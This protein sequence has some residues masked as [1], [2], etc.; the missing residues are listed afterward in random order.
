MLSNTCSKIQAKYTVQNWARLAGNAMAFNEVL[1]VAS[2]CNWTEPDQML[3]MAC[4][5]C[6]L[7]DCPTARL[8]DCP[9][10]WGNRLGQARCHIYAKVALIVT[11]SRVSLGSLST[12]PGKSLRFLGRLINAINT[13]MRIWLI[14]RQGKRDAAADRRRSSSTLPAF[15][16][17]CIWCIR[18]CCTEKCLDDPCRGTD[19]LLIGTR[20]KR[21]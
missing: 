19:C 14:G 16:L 1:R 5:D 9:P 3:I 8:P 17:I 20:S 15:W 10:I 11:Q 4:A 18:E 21:G 2:I 12:G 7:M 6:K 13:Q